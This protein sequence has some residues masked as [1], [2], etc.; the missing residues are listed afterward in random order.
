MGGVMKTFGKRGLKGCSLLSGKMSIFVAL[1]LTLGLALAGP[2]LAG[3]WAY[4]GSLDTARGGPRILLDNGQV[5]AAGGFGGS[6]EGVPLS[7]CEL[8]DPATGL[9]RGTGSMQDAR[10]EFPLIL[11]ASGKVLAIGGMGI[12][13]ELNSCEVYDPDQELWSPTG[14]LAVKR[15]MVGATRLADSTGQVLVVGGSYYDANAGQWVNLDSAEVYDPDQELW[16]G[17]GSLKT[18]RNA[19]AVLLLKTG[20]VL[21]GGGS[22]NSFLNSCEL[23]NPGTGL[24]RY[25]GSFQDAR[26]YGGNVLLPDGK[27][28]MV[29]GWGGT[30]PNTHPLSSC[31]LYDPGTGL[32][33]ATGSL[34]TARQEQPAVLLNNGEVFTFGGYGSDDNK[35]A[36]AE[37]YN[38]STGRWR[39][40]GS[41]NTARALGS[42]PLL[43]NGKVLA[44]GGSGNDG[45]LASSELYTPG[46]ALPGAY[47]LLLE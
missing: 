34:N 27:V 17:T 22:A 37:L 39:T 41:L 23:Y 7:S 32:W 20:E 3:S 11:L 12:S 46:E 42:A 31:Q 26:A 19:P 18:A 16:H 38:P 6:G 5:L 21:V 2:A 44:A 47:L 28:L 10:A 25:T 29:G 4:T 24:F 8:Y 15:M 30:W 1:I 14:P 45:R 36:S 9:W 40:T 13:G 35:L 33:S 43:P